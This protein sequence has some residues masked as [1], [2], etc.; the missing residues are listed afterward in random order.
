MN[1]SIQFD[2]IQLRTE[3]LLLRP[4]VSTDAQ[5]LFEVFSDDKVMRYWS[6]AAWSSIER[7]HDKIAQYNK[8]LAENESIGL[9]IINTQTNLVIGTC[10]L[11]QLDEQ[12]RRAEIGYGMA[13]TSWGKGYMREALTYLI[14][15]GFDVLDLNRIEADIDPRN[16][17]SLR[18]VERLGFI[19]E[20][21]LRERWIVESEISDSCIYGLLRRDWLTQRSTK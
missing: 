10:S 14:N 5:A 11:F 21:H 13:S 1:N 17:P 15:F 6:G 19:K 16:D 2:Q 8:S 20:G 12:C 3:R 4:L 7:A 18:S 9:G